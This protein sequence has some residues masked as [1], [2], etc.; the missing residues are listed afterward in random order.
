MLAFTLTDDDTGADGEIASVIITANPGKA[1]LFSVPKRI[2]FTKLPE[3]NLLQLNF[4]TN[5]L[6]NR[7]RDSKLY[8]VL[9]L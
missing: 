3:V 8:N 6:T 5:L 4:T 2:R 9:H 7:R 1:T